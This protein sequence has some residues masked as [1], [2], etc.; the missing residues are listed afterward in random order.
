LER[1]FSLLGVI[2][3]LLVL[4]AQTAESQSLLTTTTAK[5]L[6]SFGTCFTEAQDHAGRAWA[7]MPTSEGGTFTDSGASGAAPYWLHVSTSDRR[8]EIRLIG[9]GSAGAPKL[10]MAAIKQCR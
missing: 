1:W 5:S 3:V 6:D 2:S 7:F 10:V 4:A 9:G 8:G